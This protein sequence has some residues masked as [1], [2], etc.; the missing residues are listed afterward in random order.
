M[1]RVYV[2]ATLP[3]LR[4]YVAA[5]RIPA[6]ADRVVA[7]GEDEESEYAALM[8]A[9]DLSAE[10]QQPGARRVV[11]AVVT[12]AVEGELRWSD[13]VAVHADP[14]ERAADADPDEDLAWYA[15]QEVPDLLDPGTV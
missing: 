5:G 11:V 14:G 15:T 6:E 1:A 12:A 4:E 10:A 9:A 8:T 7:P 13:V 2:P 3:L